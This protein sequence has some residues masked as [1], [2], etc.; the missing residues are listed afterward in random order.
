MFAHAFGWDKRKLEV[1]RF[2]DD[3]CTSILQYKREMVEMENNLVVHLIYVVATLS[4]NVAGQDY[5][6]NITSGIAEC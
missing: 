3:V 2:C 4:L 5:C 6:L 1:T